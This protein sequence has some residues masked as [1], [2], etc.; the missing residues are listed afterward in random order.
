M[1][2]YVCNPSNFAKPTE[3]R[4][5]EH[6]RCAIGCDAKRNPKF[7][8]WRNAA[9]ATCWPWRRSDPDL[10][11]CPDPFLAVLAH[12]RF[13]VNLLLAQR[14]STAMIRQ[15]HAINVDQAMFA[16]PGAIRNCLETIG[17][18]G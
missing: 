7:A 3:P 5:P 13:G 2:K 15:A 9:T 6:E 8:G 10:S 4:H 18:L 1:T 17:T 11:R 16:S 14:T 12:G